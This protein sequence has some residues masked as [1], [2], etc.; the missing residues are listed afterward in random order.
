MKRRVKGRKRKQRQ[1]RALLIAGIVAVLVLAVF[2]VVYFSMRSTVNKVAK[3]T[4][5]DHVY[6]ENVDVSGMKAAQAKEALEAQIVTYQ[7]ETVTLIADETSA[8]VTLGDLGFQIKDLDKLIKMA[9]AYGK[10]G[11][12]W[13]RHKEIKSLTKEAKKFAVTYDIDEKAV[14]KTL[15]EKLPRLKNAAQ[16]ATITRQNGQF[17]IT[18][19]KAGKKI[20]VAESIDM[21]RDYLNQEW[22]DGAAKKVE[23]HTVVEEPG[24]T[25]EQLSQIQSALG[26][27]STYFGRGKS[28]REKNII[29]A[30]SRINGIV[31]MPG[32]ILSA[33]EAMGKTTEENGYFAAGSYLDG[34]VVDSVGGGVCQV[35]TTLYNAVL[36]AELEITERWSHSMLVDY[37]KPSMDAAIAEGYKDLKFKN[38]TDA[39][40]YIEGIIK[41]GNVVFT[42]YGK[43]TRAE[44]RKVSYESEELS[45][46]AAKKKFVASNDAVGTLKV[47]VAGHDAVKA[48]LW[49]IVTENGVEVSRKVM[50]N[51]SYQTS[52]ATYKV[53]TGTDNA[54]AKKVLTEAIKTQNEATIRAAIAQAKAIIAAASQPTNGTPS[55]TPPASTTPATP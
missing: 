22:K 16:D 47:S 10:E 46:T 17:V 49:K 35:S 8:E 20:A 41:N 18:E 4:I 54:E 14:K 12:V 1:R 21:I 13:A 15:S 43:E 45:R 23:L 6:I 25:K 50:N 52:A 34:E 36:L 28:N 9:V 29:N 32:E 24:V 33:S 55:T 39:P 48:K 27:F 19:G 38:N 31:L 37:V 44:G 26:T 40:V 42:I 51:S 7:S 53:G 11:S 30:T 3:D 2:L 5:W